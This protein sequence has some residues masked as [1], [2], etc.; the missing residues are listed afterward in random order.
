[1]DIPA[2]QGRVMVNVTDERHTAV[3]CVN[4]VDSWPIRSRYRQV[5]DVVHQGMRR[6]RPYST[7][8][9]SGIMRTFQLDMPICNIGI[10]NSRNAMIR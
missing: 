7:A 5:Q 6:M 9:S 4:W 3:A 8:N 2:E 10:I 1:M